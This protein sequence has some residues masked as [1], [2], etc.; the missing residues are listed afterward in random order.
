MHLS[1]SEPTWIASGTGTPRGKTR[2]AQDSGPPT[3]RRMHPSLSGPASAA[4]GIGT[5]WGRTWYARD[6]ATPTRRQIH[7]RFWARGG[8]EGHAPLASYAVWLAIFQ[9]GVSSSLAKGNHGDSSTAYD[10]FCTVWMFFPCWASAPGRSRNSTAGWW[11]RYV[12]LDSSCPPGRF[13]LRRPA[14]CCSASTLIPRRGAFGHTRVR[15][16]KYMHHGCF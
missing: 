5:P 11:R 4:G 16:C 7:L 14:S 1:P 15:F 6:P 10:H 3:P 9:V 12:K 13:S 8:G 2:Y